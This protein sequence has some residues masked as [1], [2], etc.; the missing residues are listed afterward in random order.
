MT[1]QK[2]VH[3]FKQLLKVK[4]KTIITQNEIICKGGL[5]MYVFKSQSNLLCDYN[6]HCTL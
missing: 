2:T 5:S 1:P 3:L 6:N 4:Y